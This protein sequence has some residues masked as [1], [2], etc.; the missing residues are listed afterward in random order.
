MTDDDM[1]TRLHGAPPAR[2][3]VLQGELMSF[4]DDLRTT[5]SGS[6]PGRTAE[7]IAVRVVQLVRGRSLQVGPTG[8]EQIRQWATA[9]GFTEAEK[10]LMSLVEQF[11]IDVHGVSDEQFEVLR[12]HY[13]DREIMAL[14]YHA[15]LC[16]GFAK[17]DAVWPSEEEHHVH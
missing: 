8:P 1:P 4:V 14:L 5:A 11:V 9:D 12:Q 2:Y 6:C 10:T 15:A 3:E 13:C 16:D 17:L 7:L